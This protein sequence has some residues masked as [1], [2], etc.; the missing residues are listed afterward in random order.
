MLV[1]LCPKNA[2]Q[3]EEHIFSGMRVLFEYFDLF[4]QMARVFFSYLEFGVVKFQLEQIDTVIAAV[5]DKINLCSRHRCV[6]LFGP[7]TFILTENATT[8][9]ENVTWVGGM[10]VPSFGK[11]FFGRSEEAENPVQSRQRLNNLLY[12]DTKLNV[13]PK[14]LTHYSE[15]IH[16]PD[17]NTMPSALY[18]NN[19]FHV[20]AKQC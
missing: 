13:A 18:V 9:T 14:C 20:W 3:G 8:L 10:F 12:E 4:A 19:K 2:E 1:S 7:F 15:A 16:A 5:K 6:A 11:F 17:Q